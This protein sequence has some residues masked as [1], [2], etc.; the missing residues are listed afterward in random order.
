ALLSSDT[1]PV[2]DFAS[3]EGLEI[4]KSSDESYRAC[5]KLL[6]EDTAAGAEGARSWMFSGGGAPAM[7]CVAVADL[8]LGR[9]RLAAVRLLELSERRDVGPAGTKATV[10][11]EAALAWLDAEEPEFAVEAIETAIDTEPT[12]VDLQVVAAKAYASAERWQAASDAVDFVEAANVETAEVFLIRARAMRAL[13]KNQEAAEDV[14]RTLKIDPF[15]LD[16][17]VLRGELV[18]SGIYIAANYAP[19]DGEGNE[20]ETEGGLPTDNGQPNALP[21]VPTEPGVAL[22]LPPEF[23]TIPEFDKQ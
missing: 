18:Q 7:H 5:I 17:L 16:A 4:Y 8:A 3:P 10:L 14:V 9:P 21:T 22:T 11:A 15:N 19:K 6:A 20:F 13:G 2:P 1:P 23:R 12:R